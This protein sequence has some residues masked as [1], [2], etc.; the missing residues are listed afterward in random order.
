MV[1][2]NI[3]VDLSDVEIQKM[4]SSAVHKYYT[5]LRRCFRHI[6]IAIVLAMFNAIAYTYVARISGNVNIPLMVFN[7]A[8]LILCVA[9]L[10]YMNMK[11]EQDLVMA[12]SFD[13]NPVCNLKDDLSDYIE[14]FGDWKKVDFLRTV[15]YVLRK[16]KD[17]NIHILNESY[18]HIADDGCTRMIPFDESV[19]EDNC[20]ILNSYGENVGLLITYDCIKVV[21]NVSEE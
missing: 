2:R 8:F 3:T 5:Y 7:W 21:G 1:V 4:F 6:Y 18:Y 14:L 19:I 16:G 20:I 17:A 11:Y 10:I 12:E 13:K 15:E 9:A